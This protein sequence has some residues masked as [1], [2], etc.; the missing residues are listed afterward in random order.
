MAVCVTS[1][2]RAVLAVAGDLGVK[3]TQSLDCHVYGLA[4]PS[5]CG[6]GGPHGVCKYSKKV[7]YFP[8]TE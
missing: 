6:S 5:C 2:G 8:D 7:K 4:F 1:R 3:E